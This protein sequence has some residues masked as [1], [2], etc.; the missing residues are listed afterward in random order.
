[1]PAKPQPVPQPVPSLEDDLAAAAPRTAQTRECVVVQTIRANPEKAET[2]TK[3]VMD[4]SYGADRLA[5][6]LGKHGVR[7]S[8]SGIRRH[9]RQACP[10]FV[11]PPTQAVL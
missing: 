3:Y 1:M 5:A 9:R 11:V 2:L 8:S 10:C 6:V 7:M 4:L